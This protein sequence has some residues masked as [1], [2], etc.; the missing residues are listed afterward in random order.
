VNDTEY[1]ESGFYVPPIV[2][3]IADLVMK[4]G[5][6]VGVLGAAYLIYGVFFGLSA[7]T[8]WDPQKQKIM[9]GNINIASQ[10]MMIGFGAASLCIAVVFWLEEVTGYVLLITA[11]VLGLGLPL[12]FPMLGG[13]KSS[14][15]VAKAL[16]GFPQG[17]IVPGAVGALLV[18]RD[19]IAKFTNAIQRRGADTDSSKMEFGADAK[20][21]AKPLRTSLIGKCWEG[22][23]CRDWVR[24]HCPIY[25]KREACWRIRRG[26][27]C[28]QEIVSAAAGKAHGGTQLEMAPSSQYNYANPSSPGV[29]KPLKVIL[30]DAQKAERCRNCVIYNDH[31]AEKYKIVMPLAI[32][33]TIVLCILLAPLMRVG[34]GTSMS[35]IESLAGRLAFAGSQDSGLKLTRPNENVQWVL[36]GAFSLMIISKALQVVE[37]CVFVKKI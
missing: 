21:E 23:Y 18:V 10:A 8:S 15:G 25:Q 5:L 36:V 32:A 24:P 6:L 16:A 12:I 28:D 29:N 7:Y 13:E 37:W 22:S 19:I 35:G 11:A 26:C 31:Q 1:E 17:M 3:A 4:L 9:L 20:R 33:V 30:N 2:Y 14:I 34:I 27:Y